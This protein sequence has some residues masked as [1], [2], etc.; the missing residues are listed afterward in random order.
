M[1]P[2]TEASPPAPP[3]AIPS[4]PAALPILQHHCTKRSC[5]DRTSTRKSLE[6]CW[7][8]GEL[9]ALLQTLRDNGTL[10]ELVRE[11][12]VCVRGCEGFCAKGW[13]AAWVDPDGEDSA[14]RQRCDHRRLLPAGPRDQGQPGLTEAAGT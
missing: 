8:L 11:L 6:Q 3:S 4:T 2:N 13:G 9:R 1:V 14:D 5:I 7:D 10:A 12:R